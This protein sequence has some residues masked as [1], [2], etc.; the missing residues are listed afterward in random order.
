MGWT[1]N[2][3]HRGAWWSLLGLCTVPIGLVILMALW[4]LFH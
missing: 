1:L 4:W 2:F 3:A